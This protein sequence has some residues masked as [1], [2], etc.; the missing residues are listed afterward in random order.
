MKNVGKFIIVFVLLSVFTNGVFADGDKSRSGL[1][2]RYPHLERER[3]LDLFGVYWRDAKPNEYVFLI[4]AHFG[5]TVFILIGNVIGTPAKAVYNLCD[6]NFKGDDYLPP[7]Q[8]ANEYFAPVG[9][10][11][12]GAPFWV[13]EKILYEGPI[14]LYDSMFENG[15]EEYEFA[16][17]DE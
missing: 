12:L 13:L 14:Q 7:V 9:G 4:P 8:F 15:G 6:L 2:E 3:G 1:R 5:A 16:D 10:Y 11:I 17:D